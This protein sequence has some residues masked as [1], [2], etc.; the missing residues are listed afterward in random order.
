MGDVM[1]DD[2]EKFEIALPKE[3]KNDSGYISV[4]YTDDEYEIAFEGWQARGEHDRKELEELRTR[5]SGKTC[6]VPPEFT[7]ELEETNKQR[8]EVHR[9]LSAETAA[10]FTA[11]KEFEA[12]KQRIAAAEK[13]AHRWGALWDALNEDTGKQIQALEKKLAEQQALLANVY[14]G[15]EELQTAEFAEDADAAAH[16][17]QKKISESGTEELTKREAA[18]E[19]RGYDKCAAEIGEYDAKAITHFSAE[20]AKREAAARQQGFEEGKQSVD[21]LCD[22]SYIA[23]M[24]FGWNCAVTED[25][26]Q[27]HAAI[28]S[29]TNERSRPLPPQVKGE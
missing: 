16:S 5:L 18:A 28:N 2:R 13:E 8:L 17:M 15:L 7:A 4:F 22:S 26:K 10:K 27:F 1:N 20:I 6:F 9:L 21:R 29:R 23:G 24:K 3:V 14:R 12:A 19:Q 25:E 11:I